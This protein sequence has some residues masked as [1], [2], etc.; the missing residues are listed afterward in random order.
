MA[1]SISPITRQKKKKPKPPTTQ[2]PNQTD[3]IKTAHNNFFEYVFS[4][5]NHA[6][7]FL[8]VYGPSEVI[9]NLVLDDLDF[10]KD[11]FIDEHLRQN[12]TDVF[13][14]API[15]TT[16]S[17]TSANIYILFEHKSTSE[18][19]VL[20]QVLRYMSERWRIDRKNGKPLR[21]SSW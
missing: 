7:E 13:Y 16:Q 17:S 6:R 19:D 8:A 4:D 9:G 15:A 2:A 18:A 21:Q 3:R 10:Q 11:D 5:L 20:E 14:E 12:R 1:R